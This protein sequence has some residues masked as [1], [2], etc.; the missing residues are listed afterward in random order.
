[1]YYQSEIYTRRFQSLD[2]FAYVR[3]GF[4]AL[5]EDREEGRKAK[6]KEGAHGAERGGGGGTGCKM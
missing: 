2:I 5:Q 4:S 6:G 3:D 1:M